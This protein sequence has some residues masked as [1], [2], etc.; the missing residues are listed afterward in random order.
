MMRDP[1]EVK[2][3]LRNPELEYT[4]V[5]TDVQAD[6]TL[7]N[8]SITEQGQKYEN[9]N[10][11]HNENKKPKCILMYINE[12]IVLEPLTMEERGRLITAIFEYANGVVVDC[13]EGGERF[14]WPVFR[15][16]IDAQFAKY[17]ETCERNR[18]N[19]AGKA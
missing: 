6:S 13:I 8:E 15:S 10:C 17:R 14:I 1:E 3:I 4:G 5:S 11:E 16:R 12:I 9:L 7:E 18:R 2:R 19:R